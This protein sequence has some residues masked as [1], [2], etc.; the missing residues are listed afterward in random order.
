MRLDYLKSFVGVVNYKSFSLAAK[1]LFLSQPTISTHIKQLEA[2]LGVQLLVRSTRDILL[3]KEGKAFYPYAIQLLEIENKAIGQLK[4]TADGIEGTI[5][6]AVSSVP[7]Y[8]M[9]PDF[10]GYFRNKNENINFKVMEGD[11]GDVLQ[12]IF[13]FEV[14]IG[15]GSLD[16]GSEKIH[17]EVLF[18][19]EIILI[20]PN[21]QKYRSMNGKF[22]IEQ[23]K[24]EKYIVREIGS[25]TKTITDNL[26]M[27]L[28][29]DPHALNV[30]VQFQSSEMVR[31]AVES[32]TGVAF[33]SKI[34][35][36]ESLDKQKVLG[37]SFEGTSSTRKIYLLYHKDRM[38]GNSCEEVLRE[39]REYC[40]G[41]FK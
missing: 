36:K 28:H 23:L 38:L 17:S 31:R 20:T 35:A 22:P 7:G 2:E 12:K 40:Q 15:I 14:E 8:Y 1:Y 18:E 10:L 41:K 9:L 29:L 24:K 27:E 37:F 6:M 11:S 39:L 30:A 25:G 19:D 13:D 26:E 21:T 16:S 34:A 3:S 5:S 32:G 33:I 4:K